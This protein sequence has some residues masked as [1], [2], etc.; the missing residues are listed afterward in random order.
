MRIGT[1][2][3]VV[4]LALA[5]LPTPAPAQVPSGP[6]SIHVEAVLGEPT[7]VGGR[8][9]F[10]FNGTAILTSVLVEGESDVHSVLPT[11][12]INEDP[13]DI[14]PAL[15][16]SYYGMELSGGP[17]IEAVHVVCTG[18]V[19]EAGNGTGRCAIS[20]EFEGAGTWAGEDRYPSAFSRARH[21][22]AR[23]LPT[24]R[25]P[26]SLDSAAASRLTASG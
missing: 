17:L 19:D 15:F 3:L 7:I 1:V 26:L 25:L 14:K 8:T 6:L 5:A 12:A 23:C 20:G 10:P 22:L 21:A 24:L 2:A 13:S 11:L 4:A 18:M 16:T 9:V